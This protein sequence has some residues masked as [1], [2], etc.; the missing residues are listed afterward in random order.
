MA[1][2]MVSARRFEY[3]ST[4]SSRPS[5]CALP[6]SG[7]NQQGSGRAIQADAARL[8]HDEL[9]VFCQRADRDQRAHQHRQR[10]R[11]NK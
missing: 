6:I 4:P 9:A 1:S 5:S 2:L 3:A 7:Q 10:N 8:H 11:G